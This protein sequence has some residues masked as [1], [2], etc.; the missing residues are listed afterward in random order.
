MEHGN[1]YQGHH[2]LADP[3][4]SWYMKHLLPFTFIEIP[5]WT[6][7]YTLF[8]QNLR[9]HRWTGQY[10]RHEFGWQESDTLPSLPK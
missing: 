6:M 8:N 4:L 2:V 5:V 9:Q 1:L 3:G 10:W 7:R